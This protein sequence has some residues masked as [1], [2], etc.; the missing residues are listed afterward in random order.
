MK[1]FLQEGLHTYAPALIALSEFRR[2]IRSRLQN[3]LDEF[4]IQFADLGLSV[5]EFRPDGAKLDDPDLGENNS[6]IGLRR[7]Y[8]TDIYTGCHLQWDLG[9]PK[10]EQVWVGIWIY[11]GIRTDRDRLFSDLQKQRSP[12]SKTDLDQYS[13][14]SSYLSSY[15]DSDSFYSFDETF[16]TMIEEWVGLLFGVGRIKKYLSAAAIS[17]LYTSASF[18]DFTAA[19]PFP[20]RA[21]G[22]AQG[23]F[24]ALSFGIGACADLCGRPSLRDR[25][26]HEFFSGTD[27]KD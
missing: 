24:P 5:D 23:G 8:G 25:I 9:E 1:R 16:R 19:L 17:R 21:G 3:V 11:V 7:N 12:L 27:R 20:A 18:R 10:D 22:S 4:T 14:G 15:C 13:D 6:L 26:S 2:Q